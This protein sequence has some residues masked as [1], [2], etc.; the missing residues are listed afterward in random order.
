MPA[1]HRL[2]PLAWCEVDR[3]LFFVGVTL[4]FR[5]VNAIAAH[6]VLASADRPSYIDTRV[7]ALLVPALWGA[8]ALWMVLGAVG[9]GLRRRRPDSKPYVLVVLVAFWV[10]SASFAVMF[11]L[12]TGPFW[13]VLVG[14]SVV[15]ILFFGFARTILTFAPGAVVLS[16]AMAATWTGAMRYAPLLAHP[17]YDAAG[18]PE[19]QFLVVHVGTSAAVA[20]VVITLVQLL[21]RRLRAREDALERLARVDALT[22]LG[23]RRA[24]FDKL[25]GELVR[26]KRHGGSIGLVVLDLDHFKEINDTHGHPVGDQALRAVAQALR[27]AV[28]AEDFVARIGGE[29]LALVLPSTDLEGARIVAER[30]RARIAAIALTP[31]SSI[32]VSATFGV[33]SIPEG[34]VTTAERAMRDADAALYRGKRE[35]RNRVVVASE[36]SELGA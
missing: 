14:A 16:G 2:D 19:L 32:S 33:T 7:L 27:E 35:G 18:R 25:H 9:L 17:P 12:T 15:S 31:G 36:P 6:H 1:H 30:C 22:E 24:F 20:A 23:N 28:R 29:E 26:Q 21:V 10:T 11:G 13:V 4:A 3:A 34:V 5:L 8:V